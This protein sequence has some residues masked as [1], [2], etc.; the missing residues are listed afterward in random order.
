MGARTCKIVQL[1]GVLHKLAPFKD[2]YL[3]LGTNDSFWNKQ[4]RLWGRM[5]ASSLSLWFLLSLVE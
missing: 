2:I 3:F 5:A 1:L 4:P